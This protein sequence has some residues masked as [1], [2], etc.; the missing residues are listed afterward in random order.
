M[1]TC[2]PKS[3]AIWA[4]LDPSPRPRPGANANGE[5]STWTNDHRLKYSKNCGW[6]PKFPEKRLGIS[7]HHFPTSKKCTRTSV[8][9]GFFNPSSQFGRLRTG[10]VRRSFFNIQEVPTNSSSTPGDPPMMISTGYGSITSR[11]RDK[12]RSYRMGPPSYKW[13]YKPL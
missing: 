9:F 7:R 13:V 1:W 5:S 8:S 12:K 11:P 3:G 10:D 6:I 2:P 4:T